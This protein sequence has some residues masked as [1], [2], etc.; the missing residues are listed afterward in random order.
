MMHNLIVLHFSNKIGVSSFRD[1]PRADGAGAALC[2][3]N[4]A[5]IE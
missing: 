1:T 5:W 2:S 4:V 3:K